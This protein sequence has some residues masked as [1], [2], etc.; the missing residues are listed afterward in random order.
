MLDSVVMFVQGC[1][2]FEASITTARTL[3]FMSMPVQVM[4]IWVLPPFWTGE[5][6]KSA[7]AAAVEQFG[8]TVEEQTL[9]L[10]DFLY[11]AGERGF[12]TNADPAMNALH[13]N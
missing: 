3:E 9:L 8:R 7:Q 4:A 1:W 10:I 2:L 13:P 11:A 6:T 5:P 12:T